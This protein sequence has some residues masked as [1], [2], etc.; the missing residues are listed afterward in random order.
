[1]VVVLT[2]I[3]SSCCHLHQSSLT[4][5][6]LTHLWNFYPL[7]LLTHGGSG[8]RLGGPEFTAQPPHPR[9]CRCVPP[10]QNFRKV[11]LKHF[12]I[13]RLHLWSRDAKKTGRSNKLQ[14]SPQSEI[15]SVQ[16][17]RIPGKR[18]NLVPKEKRDLRESL[19]IMG[20]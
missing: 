11:D 5:T 10:F 13:Q 12:E 15:L 4:C 1:M 6:N 17:Q 8:A 20:T 19:D 16:G 3:I 18:K 9:S 14:K 2:V 7:P